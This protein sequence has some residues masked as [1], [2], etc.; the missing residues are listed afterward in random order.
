M[1]GSEGLKWVW[2]VCFE[3]SEWRRDGLDCVMMKGMKRRRVEMGRKRCR[4][5]RINQDLFPLVQKS[6]RMRK[7][8][9]C[10]YESGR[11]KSRW[12]VG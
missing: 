6:K 8:R 12:R 4:P 3:T 7:E 9:R 11:M 2:S 5:H 10:G 1:F